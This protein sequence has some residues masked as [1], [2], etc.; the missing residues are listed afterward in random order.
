MSLIN[1]IGCSKGPSLAEDD[2]FIFFL[3]ATTAADDLSGVPSAVA[4]RSKAKLLPRR[5]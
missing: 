5:T 3:A 1:H 2:D 4:E